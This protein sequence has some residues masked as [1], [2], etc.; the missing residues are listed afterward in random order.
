[1]TNTETL[2]LQAVTQQLRIVNAYQ[3]FLYYIDTTHIKEND[4][5]KESGLMTHFMSKLT[6][7]RRGEQYIST[8]CV[9]EWFQ[10]MNKSY[11]ADL[12][13]YIMKFHADKY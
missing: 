6:Y 12:V 5:W 10:N 11:Q 3:H 9:A 4:P 13:K 2:E 7:F 1:M 8:A